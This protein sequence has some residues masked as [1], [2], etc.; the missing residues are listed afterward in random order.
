MARRVRVPM[1]RL[2]SGFEMPALGIG[3]WRMGGDFRKDPFNRDEADRKAIRAALEA[4]VTHIDTA[5]LYAAGHAEKL[6]GDVIKDFKREKLFITSKVKGDHLDYESVLKAC[7][8]SLERLGTDYLDLYLVHWPEARF[9]LEGTMKAMD[10]L[11]KEGFVR[12]V[13]VSNFHPKTMKRAQELSENKLVVN[14]V[15][16]NL[17]VREAEK[18]GLLEYCQR[19]DAFLEAY[20]PVQ[21]GELCRSGFPVLDE[22]AG[23]YGK[24]H[25]QVA[26]NWL[27]SQRNVTTIFKAGREMHL[28]E[29]LGAL[30]WKLSPRDVERLRREFPVQVAVSE[31][32]PLE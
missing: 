8:A 27:L 5:E 16:Y 32:G 31:V 29:N 20:R 3:T 12:N 1:K 15:H 26:L 19:S 21:M 30:G 10:E 11:V 22:M 18:K 23:K 6:V 4:G 28:R 17:I 2:K 9:P 25:A 14:Q 24:T 13:G 7:R